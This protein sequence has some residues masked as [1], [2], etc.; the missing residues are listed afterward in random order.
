M[1]TIFSL[2]FFLLLSTNSFAVDVKATWIDNSNNEDGFRI[3]MCQG[4]CSTTGTW[5]IIGKVGVNVTSFFP[6]VITA[7]PVSF[8]V[9]AFNLFGDSAPSNIFVAK[10]PEQT[11][12]TFTTGP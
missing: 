12:L 6:I 4:D 1:K 9:F 8:R 11:T 10:V 3:E 7:T 5:I 2:L